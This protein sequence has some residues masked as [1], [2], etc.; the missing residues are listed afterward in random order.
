MDSFYMDINDKFGFR[1]KKSMVEN[2]KKMSMEKREDEA[3][4]G[5]GVVTI[6]TH[7]KKLMQQF[8]CKWAYGCKTW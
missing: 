2:K 1:N 6:K 5:D 3:M 8:P 4:E 7:E